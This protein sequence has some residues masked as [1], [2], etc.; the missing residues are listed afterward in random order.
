[1]F[2][3]AQE[4]VRERVV[5]QSEVPL[6][7]RG[8]SLLVGNVY[9]GHCGARLSLATAGRNYKKK[10]GTVVKKTYSCYKCYNKAMDARYRDGHSG[11]TPY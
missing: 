5:P 4:I 7:T 8:Q 2:A 11:V 1:M 9:C 6:T 3:R 10:D